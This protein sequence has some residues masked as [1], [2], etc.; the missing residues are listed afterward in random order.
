MLTQNRRPIERERDIATKREPEPFRQWCATGN[1]ICAIF[2]GRDRVVNF[3]AVRRK[4]I[5]IALVIRP[6]MVN[7]RVLPKIEDRQRSKKEEANAKERPN[8][9]ARPELNKT[10][11]PR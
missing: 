8:Y 9:S 4:R 10:A 11:V 3:D 1:V 5:R 6:R 7:H 2:R